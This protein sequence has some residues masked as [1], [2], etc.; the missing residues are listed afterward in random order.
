MA[1][2]TAKTEQN[3][4]GKIYVDD[5]CIACDACVTSAPNNFRINEDEG[6]AYVSKQ[7]E[8]PEEEEQVREAMEGCPVE[9]IGNDGNEE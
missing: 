1:D 9:A 3:V 2:K 5:T 6:H 7:P 8:N 4:T